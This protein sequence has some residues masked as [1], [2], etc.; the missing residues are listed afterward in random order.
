MTMSLSGP[1]R[2]EY[3]W[4]AAIRRRDMVSSALGPLA[5]QRFQLVDVCFQGS[6]RP[7]PWA[8]RCQVMI[9]S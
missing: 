3:D 2:E 4:H 7:H 5:D 6:S 1:N 8:K 9:R